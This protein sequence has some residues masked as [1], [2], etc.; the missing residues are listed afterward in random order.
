LRAARAKATEEKD[1]AARKKDF[2]DHAPGWMSRVVY[3]A[4]IR[5]ACNAGRQGGGTRESA[6]A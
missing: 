1:T 5:H 4:N 6:F 2:N 3:H